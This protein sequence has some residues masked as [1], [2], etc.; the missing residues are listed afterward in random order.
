MR[1]KIAVVLLVF[2][3][4]FSIVLGY[5][6]FINTP[7]KT[8][9]QVPFNKDLSKGELVVAVTEDSYQ[10]GA[11]YVDT[12]NKTAMYFKFDRSEKKDGFVIFYYKIDLGR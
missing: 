3:F 9:P 12:L 8:I 7:V 6:I 11:I 1:L 5:Y 4:I 2:D 10:T